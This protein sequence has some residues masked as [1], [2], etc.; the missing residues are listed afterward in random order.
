MPINQGF[1]ILSAIRRWHLT[2]V[3]VPGLLVS[4]RIAICPT[5]TIVGDV[6]SPMRSQNPTE[7][8]RRRWVPESMLRLDS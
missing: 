3:R 2:F 8:R 5:T 6:V 1:H 7:P 4:N